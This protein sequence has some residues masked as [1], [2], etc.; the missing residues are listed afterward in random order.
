ML[1]GYQ[2]SSARG[3]DNINIVT[4]KSESSFD[5]RRFNLKFLVK[6]MVF[7]QASVPVLRFSPA[8]CIPSTLQAL[9]Q[10][11]NKFENWNK[12]QIIFYP[13]LCRYPNKKLCF[14]GPQGFALVPFRSEMGKGHW[15]NDSEKKKRSTRGKIST[16]ATSST[17][18]SRRL[19]QN[20]ISTFRL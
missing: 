18:I 8:R 2:L 15:W 12:N 4:L 6:N 20:W 5:H 9:H 10:L 16:T 11:N 7:R 17:L 13:K 3:S 14:G 1:E 19:A